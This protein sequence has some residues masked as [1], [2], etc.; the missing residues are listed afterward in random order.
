MVDY[1]Y[2]VE[3]KRTSA[4]LEAHCMKVWEN[5]RGTEIYSN[6]IRPMRRR[7]LSVIKNNG[8]ATKY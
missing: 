8:G 4:E 2:G 1:I 3:R 5:I 6:I 7:L